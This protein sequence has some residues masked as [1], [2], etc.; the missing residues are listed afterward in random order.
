MPPPLITSQGLLQA[1]AI[2]PP[3]VDIASVVRAAGGDLNKARYESGP[4]RLTVIGI[5]QEALDEALLPADVLFAARMRIKQQAS[6]ELA[7]RTDAGMSWQGKVVQIDE[8]STGRMTAVAFGLQLGAATTVSWRMADNTPLVLD[9]ATMI[10]M[11]TAAMGYVLALRNRYWQIVDAAKAAQDEAAL[12]AIDPSAGWP[13]GAPPPPA[14][15]PPP[16]A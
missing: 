9:K 2:V 3:T 5:S 11:A 7:R 14:P 6:A 16:P 12:A 15:A 1:T 10:G 8:T 4:E 13:T